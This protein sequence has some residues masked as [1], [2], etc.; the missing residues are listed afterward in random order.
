MDKKTSKQELRMEMARRRAEFV[1]D[2]KEVALAAQRVMS[3][4]EALEAFGRAHTILLY[5]SL[6]DELPTDGMIEK[7][8]ATKRIVLPVV[9]GD[10]LVLREYRAGAL[11]KGYRGIMEPSASCLQVL[12]SEIDFAVVPG[13][14][15]SP[16]GRRMGRGKG[17]YDRLLPQLRC[18]SVGVCFPCQVVSDVPCD[19]NDMKVESIIY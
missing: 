17:Y 18:P 4:I 15:F 14:A 7:W 6:P 16:D 19:T 3:G 1:R 5:A 11:E 8:S 12:P 13:V 2:G 9:A 10:S